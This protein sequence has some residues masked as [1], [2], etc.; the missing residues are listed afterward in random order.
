MRDKRAVIP[1]GSYQ[2]AIGVTLSLPSVVGRGVISILQPDLTTAERS[3]LENSAES[4]RGALARIR[5]YQVRH[6]QANAPK[7]G[8]CSA[9]FRKDNHPTN[10]D[11]IMYV[12]ATY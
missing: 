8:T 10:N 6:T 11:A 9:V 12:R 4:L 7:S 3:A 1:I 5:K 2:R